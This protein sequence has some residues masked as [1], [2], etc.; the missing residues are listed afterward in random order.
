MLISSRSVNKDGRHRQFLFLIDQCLKN[1]FLWN[2]WPNEPKLGRKHPWKVL[3][4]DCSFSS[5][6]LTNMVA[7]GNSCFWLAD[8]KK[9]SS[10]KPLGQMNQNLVGSIYGMSSI[11]IAHFIAIRLSNVATTGN[12]C[13]WLVD[14]L[15]NLL[16]WNSL[17]KWTETW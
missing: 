14:F 12:F 16:L 11:K 4:I 1:L 6:L 13:F 3:Y 8:L 17:T 2:A 9:S 7:I 5:D 15:K 10:L